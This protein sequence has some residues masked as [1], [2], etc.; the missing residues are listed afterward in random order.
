MWKT[1]VQSLG[2]E[3]PLEEG[4]ATQSS[5]P[6]WRIPV[7]RGA[8]WATIHRVAKSQIWLKQLNTYTWATLS[9]AWIAHSYYWESCGMSLD[10]KLSL[11]LNV[12]AHHSVS[13]SCFSG[14]KSWIESIRGSQLGSYAHSIIIPQTFIKWEKDYSSKEEINSVQFSHSVMS[15]SLQSQ[16]PQHSRPPCLSPT[17]GVHPNPCPLSWWCH[18]TISSFVVP[19]SCPQ[20]FPASGSFQM[21]Q[22]FASGG[23]STGV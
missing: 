11:K 8:W 4:I 23:Q 21:S 17:P 15:D 19:F 2:Q 1:Q 20:P 3:G 16:E 5:I 14:F 18:P 6:T 10:R 13:W 9:A 12:T 7:D 22:L